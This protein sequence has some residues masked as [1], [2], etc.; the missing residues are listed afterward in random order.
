MSREEKLNALLR[1]SAK[2]GLRERAAWAYLDHRSA[3]ETQ[4]I[5]LVFGAVYNMLDVLDNEI[6]VSRIDAQ[7][8]NSEVEMVID[9]LS[10]RAAVSRDKETEELEVLIQVKKN[11][12][13]VTIKS[14]ADLGAVFR[15][16]ILPALEPDERE[17]STQTGLPKPSRLAPRGTIG[18][19]D[20]TITRD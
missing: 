17:L 8:R 16:D 5:N 19:H 14:L 1:P 9:G 12:T 2:E 7:E 3:Q 4:L 11:T 6:S 10:F 13:W 18:S 20:E 15:T